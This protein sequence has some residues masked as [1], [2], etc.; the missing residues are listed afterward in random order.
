MICSGWQQFVHANVG[1]SGQALIEYWLT[2]YNNTCPSGRNSFSFTGDTDIYCY[3][4]SSKAVSVPNQPITNLAQLTLRGDV[5]ASEDRVTLTAGTTAYSAVG[6][7]AVNAAAGWRFAE[8]NV[9]GHAGNSGGG[10]Q[11]NFNSGSTIVPR[12]RIFYGG[13]N[14]PSCAAQGFTGETNNL[15]FGPS[16]PASSTSGPA[17]L[18]TDSSAG[19]SPS[20]CAA[21]TTVG[22]PH[23][24]TF[25]GLFYAIKA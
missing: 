3:K 8:F 5:S 12:T 18:F 1:S 9:F 13:T 10:G 6:D 23:W 25:Y 24:A 7:N 11:A 20:Y 15:S 16:A 17:V 21:A 19:G 22:E 2:R 4:S 14:A